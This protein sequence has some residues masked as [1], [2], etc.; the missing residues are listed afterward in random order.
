MPAQNPIG[1][2]KFSGEQSQHTSPKRERGKKVPS[3][4]LRAG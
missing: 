2:R 3:L 1:T 4:A